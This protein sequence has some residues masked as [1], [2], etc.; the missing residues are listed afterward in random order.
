MSV[1]NILMF[2]KLYSLVGYFLIWLINWLIRS[3]QLDYVYDIVW[4][5]WLF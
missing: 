1:K 3:F 2:V 5:N 4:T